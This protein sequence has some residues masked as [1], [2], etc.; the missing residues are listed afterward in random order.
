MITLQG[1]NYK[2]QVCG[3]KVEAL[4]G[5]EQVGEQRKCMVPVLLEFIMSEDDVKT[6]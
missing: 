4:L 2:H 5:S 1:V 6:N 3:W